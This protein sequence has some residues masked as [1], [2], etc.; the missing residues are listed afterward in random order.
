[1]ED[2]G[3]RARGTHRAGSS[4]PVLGSPPPAAAPDALLWF[5]FRLHG[6][7]PLPPARGGGARRKEG[8]R[9]RGG[10]YR[11]PPP[12][13]ASGGPRLRPGA[14]QLLLPAHARAEE[15]EREQDGYQRKPD[16]LRGNASQDQIRPH[17]QELR[18]RL[19]RG[20]Q[21]A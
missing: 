1:M 5:G 19:R 12:R 3:Q 21:R 16:I 13:Q 17:I 6:C 15:G 14:R 9:V 10:P 11:Q 4:S 18:P 7:T 8:G 20:G 2:R